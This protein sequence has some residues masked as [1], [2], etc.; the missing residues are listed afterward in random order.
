[1]WVKSEMG[2]GLDGEGLKGGAGQRGTTRFHALLPGGQGKAKHLFWGWHHL[3]EI[4]EV[5]KKAEF[6]L[7]VK[8]FCLGNKVIC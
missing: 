3:L 1:M 4:S 2:A 8:N 6:T 5:S 7:S